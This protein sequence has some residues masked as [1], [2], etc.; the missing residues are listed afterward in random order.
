MWM[1]LLNLH[2][3]NQIPD[4]GNLLVLTKMADT[5]GCAPFLGQTSTLL[6]LSLP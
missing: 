1:I 4:D 6:M 5:D 2:A 3:N